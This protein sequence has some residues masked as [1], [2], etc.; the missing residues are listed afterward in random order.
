MKVWQLAGKLLWHTLRGRGGD[1]VFLYHSLSYGQLSMPSACEDRDWP[2]TAFAW[3]DDM[4]RYVVL[5]SEHVMDETAFARWRRDARAPL[6][7][8]PEASEA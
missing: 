3:E 4:D 8:R 1:E 5:E 7:G 2:L 6:E